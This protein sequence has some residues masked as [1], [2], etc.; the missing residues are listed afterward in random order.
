MKKT[1]YLTAMLISTLL[2]AILFSTTSVIAKE[3]VL[4]NIAQATDDFVLTE[5]TTMQVVVDYLL[6][7]YA[8]VSALAFRT[9][10]NG[11]T[12]RNSLAQSVGILDGVN[13]VS[14]SICSSED[15]AVMLQNALPLYEAMRKVPMEPF[16]VNGMAQPIF[17]MGGNTIGVTN[18]DTTGEGIA[19]FIVFVETDL[20]TDADGK[21]DLIKVLV[22]LPRAAVD[23]GMKVG[24]VYHAQPY[25]EG[26]IGGTDHPTAVRTP[27]QQY[28]DSTGE[29]YPN[30]FPHSALHG[31]APHRVPVGERTTAEMVADAAVDCGRR[32][33]L[34]AD[35]CDC[36]WTRWNYQW[37]TTSAVKD[38]NVTVL[39]GRTN[40]NQMGSRT[41]YDYFLTRGF[42]HV[43]TAGLG[44]LEG[45][46]H[47]SYGADIEINAY[48]A[49]IDWLNGNAKAFTDK[50]SNIEVV[51]DWSNG[52]VGMT[53]VSYGGTTPMGLAT[54]GVKGL[55]AI[56]PECG[57]ISYYDY[58]NSQGGQN[59][60][61][62]Y[63]PGL[64]GWTL[65]AF[66]RHDWHGSEFRMR[67]LGYMQQMFLEA[68][69][70]N[71]NY[72]VH[73]ARRD[74]TKEN[75]DDLGKGWGPSKITAAMLITTGGNDANV[76][77]K[78]SVLMHEAGQK[79]SGV[80]RT[81]F[82]QGVHSSLNNHVIDL[83][84]GREIVFQDLM[85]MWYSHYLYDCNNGVA[86]L[87][88]PV[89]ASN[90]QTGKFEAY[91]AWDIGPTFVMDK[92]N[93]GRTTFPEQTT[94]AQSLASIQADGVTVIETDSV[95][96]DVDPNYNESAESLLPVLPTIPEDEEDSGFMGIDAT[97]LAG[98]LS[99]DPERFL[100][101]NSANAGANWSTQLNDHTAGSILWSAVL[102][103]DMVIQGVTQFN[104]RAAIQSA[105]A[106]VLNQT[107]TLANFSQPPGQ[108]RVFARLV[109]IAAPGTRITGYNPQT[110]G[111]NGPITGESPGTISVPGVSLFRGGGLAPVQAVRFNRNTNLTYREIARGYM[112]LANPE[113][114]WMAY[115]TSADKRINI[116]ENIGVYH[117]YTMFLQPN[118][119]KV[120]EGNMLVLVLSTGYWAGSAHVGNR[121]AT[122]AAAFT[123]TVDTEVSNIV[124][125]L[126][127]PYTRPIEE[128]PYNFN[129]SMIPNTEYLHLDDTLTID[130]ILSGDLNYTLMAADIVYDTD[131]LEYTSYTH[132]SGW[133][134]AVTKLAP[135]TI[136][137]RSMPSSNMIVGSPC[138]SGVKI[139]TLEFKVKGGYE[140]DSTVTDLSFA[141]L[142]VSPAGTVRNFTTAPGKPV[143]LT[144]YQQN[145]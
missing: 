135:N 19:R 137:V 123:F 8:G 31:T 127:K 134:A 90:N 73:W 2:V 56:I 121:A 52:N 29:T 113:A 75:W 57:I 43:T 35:R 112:N 4:D 107:A 98:A 72:G 96:F 28:L 49:V 14:N 18:W 37:N 63:T 122:G 7:D 94:S 45:D 103:E 120:S 11:V 50:T 105:G 132:L 55:K 129:V 9:G 5:E 25:N 89:L 32:D 78:Q 33:M 95:E 42:A 1:K 21:L 67:Q 68:I 74:Y 104:F 44:Q 143:T 136:S 116:A 10:A 53:G 114:G 20:D 15:F 39:W 60:N 61:A 77:P 124:V 82:G 3:I 109:E 40:G 119:H 70:E 54:T 87:L 126:A 80:V 145:Q 101:V 100:L 117:D 59:W 128:E 85:N 91:E 106:N 30:Q 125:P 133:M 62:Q 144:L 130:V 88:P 27:G 118:V 38:G 79:G 13:Y 97:V 12:D 24:T 46:G 65:S 34:Y 23:K 99:D 6:L 102:E 83:L 76:S 58:Q 69:E 131:L 16:F 92:N 36:P 84:D 139:A 110:I 86:D 17:P 66:G 47:T 141:T 108:A 22:Q 48:K 26:T 41:G 115:T 71:G 111:S 93:V 81:L 138:D 140:G 64:A 51:A 142:A